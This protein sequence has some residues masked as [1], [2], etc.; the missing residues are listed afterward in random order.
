MSNLIES[1]IF[2]KSP[3]KDKKLRA[4]FT[5]EDGKKKNVDFGASGYMDYIKYYKR[6]GKQKAN[7][8]KKSY[9]ARHK[10]N[11]DWS[12]PLSAGALSRW[13]LWNK[14]TIARSISDYKKRFNI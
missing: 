13:I 7:E 9:L 11:E 5:M 12:D 1:V 14:Q 6:N 8:K 2:K 4:I 3:R 10:P